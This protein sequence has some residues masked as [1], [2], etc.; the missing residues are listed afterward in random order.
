MTK[1]DSTDSSTSGE[2]PRRFRWPAFTIVAIAI[3]AFFAGGFGGSFQGKLTEVQKND[4]AAYLSSSAEST[5]VTNESSKFLTVETIPGF[6]LFHSDSPLTEQDK[7]AIAQAR[8]AIAAVDGVDAEGMAQT[9]F[10]QDGTTASI[11]VPLVAKEDGTAVAGDVLAAT[12]ENVLTAAK[13]AAAGLEVLPAGP[14]GLLVAFIDAFAGLDG[15]LLGAALLVVVLILLVVYRS[16]VLWFFPLFSALLALGLASMV[17]YFL[18]KAEVLTLTGQ[19]QGILFVLVIGAGTDYALLLISRYREELHFYPSRFDAMIKAWK[20]SAP[21]ITASAVTVILGLLCLTFSE[22]NSNKSLGPV[23]AIGIACTYLVMMTFLPVA[24]SAAGRWVFWPRKPKV[25][26]AADL[27][28]HGL[29]GRI[30]AQVGSKDRPLWIGTTVLLAVLFLV[31]IGSLKTDGLS[32]SENFTNRPDAVVGQELYDS[33][34]DPGAGAPAVIVT[35]ADQTDAVIAAVSGVDGVSTDP[36]AVCPQVDVEKLS[37][38]VKSNPAAVASAAGQGC[39]PDFLTAAPIDGRMVVNVTLAD[40]Y[41]SPEALETVKRL[42]DA[43]HAVPGADSLVGG[44]TATTLDVQT[45]SVHDRNLIIPIVLVVIFVVLALLLRALLTP[46]ILIATVVLSFAATLGVCGLFF[47]HVFHFANADPAFPLFA[48]VFLVA[49]GIDYNIFLMTRVREETEEHGTKSGVLR[50]L[51]V[52]G[53]VITSAG[54]V[55]AATFAVLGV[56]PLVFLAEV[57]FAVAFG[58][59]LDTIIV[60]S[61]LVPALSHDIGKKIWW[62]SALAK[63]KD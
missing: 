17:I 44:S 23:A 14:G 22:L 25:D 35:N 54:V 60:R 52:T 48:F 30:A 15:A 11:F 62:P 12:E 1:L 26:E 37:A 19:S 63:A 28:T 47:T 57:G 61:I 6:V 34:F 9:Q 45:A 53:G 4:N 8:D 20:E 31:G 16:P 36:G 3:I 24:L 51:A 10:S 33:K 32:S 41:D 7:A 50:G 49:L 39:A 42:R 29:W 46:I 21:A 2:T 5:I 13:N 18:A 40:S 58:V 43:A 56:L 59:L 38:L 55:L 27:T